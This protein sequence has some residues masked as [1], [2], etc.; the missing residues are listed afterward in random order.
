LLP[1]KFPFGNTFNHT[2]KVHESQGKRKFQI[3]SHSQRGIQVIFTRVAPQAGPVLASKARKNCRD[4]PSGGRL[5]QGSLP[6]FSPRFSLSKRLVQITDHFMSGFILVFHIN[7]VI[8]F[9]CYS[10]IRLFHLIDTRFNCRV[11]IVLNSMAIGYSIVG[12]FDEKGKTQWA[13][14]V[15]SLFHQTLSG[16]LTSRS[17][18]SD[19]GLEA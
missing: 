8:F 10:D 5:Q 1:W 17:R 15:S 19:R 12:A 4:S 16:I 6:L 9:Y 18:C 7:L 2:T 13:N 14:T 3:A 11:S